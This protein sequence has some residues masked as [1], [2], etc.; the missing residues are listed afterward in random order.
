MAAMGRPSNPRLMARV[1]EAVKHL[2]ESRGSSAKQV[3]EV[4]RQGDKVPTRNLTMQVHRALKNAVTAGL[5]KLHSGRYKMLISLQTS[6][7]HG[8]AVKP[9]TSRPVQKD[10][11]V[12]NAQESRSRHQPLEAPRSRCSHCKKHKRRSSRRRRKRSVAKRR[13]PSRQSRGRKSRKLSRRGD[14]EE[15]SNRR[16]RR[17]KIAA[18]GGRQ[19]EGPA[20]TNPETARR[21]DETNEVV[22]SDSDGEGNASNFAKAKLNTDGR[23]SDTQRSQRRRSSRK[24]SSSRKRRS[25]SLDRKKSQQVRK[26]DSQ[27]LSMECCADNDAGEQENLGEL[28]G[29]N[30]C[31][32]I[33]DGTTHH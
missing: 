25:P 22:A 29:P 6:A 24:R 2:G 32:R 4:V 31:D 5:L 12:G 27:D 17:K 14:G 7:A 11:E 15:V 9:R 8:N 3:L 26:N 28:E 13:R 19:N 18:P 21:A 33:D 30:A 1:L 20:K 10:E 16:E 23:K